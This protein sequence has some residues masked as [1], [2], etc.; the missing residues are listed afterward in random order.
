MSWRGE[1][2]EEYSLREA[3]SER[4]SWLGAYESTMPGYQR[5]TKAVRSVR[6]YTQYAVMAL[7]AT[8]KHSF[9]PVR[10]V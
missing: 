6:T 8:S 4:P 9:A 7:M 1:E 5:G 2:E 10:R 3:P